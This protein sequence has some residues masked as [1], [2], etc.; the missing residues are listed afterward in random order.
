MAEDSESGRDRYQ[1][2]PEDFKEL[3]K[4]AVKQAMFLYYDDAPKVVNTKCLPDM[5]KKHHDLL[6]LLHHGAE[7]LCYTRSTVRG[8]LAL[9]HTEAGGWNLKQSETEAWLNVMSSRIMNI[10]RVV[11]QGCNKKPVMPKWAA[12]LPWKPEQMPPTAVRSRGTGSATK[13]DSDADQFVFGVNIDLVQAWRQ[14]GAGHQ[15]TRRVA[16]GSK[17]LS[18]PRSKPCSATSGLVLQKWV[19]TAASRRQSK[20]HPSQ[21]HTRLSI[22]E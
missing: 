15:S 17:V 14:R 1:G 5:I 13:R 10:C 20:S 8:G 22:S 16:N 7:N 11:G 4:P 3:I 21:N 6:A 9:L 12:E 2:T 19:R 18:R